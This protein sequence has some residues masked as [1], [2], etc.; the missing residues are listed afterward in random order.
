M[1]G[2]LWLWQIY[3][4]NTF[5]DRYVDRWRGMFCFI[6]ID[7]FS[8]AYRNRYL[9]DVNEK[10]GFDRVLRCFHSCFI[11][12]FCT[13]EVY[14]NHFYEIKSKWPILKFMI[15]NLKMLHTILATSAKSNSCPQTCMNT[16]ALTLVQWWRHSIMLSLQHM[17]IGSKQTN[18][19]MDRMITQAIQ[20]LTRVLPMIKI[21]H[22]SCKFDQY[23]SLVEFI[24]FV[25]D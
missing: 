10:I 6:F 14:Q 25:T 9:I 24:S 16:V 19:S 1:R 21:W 12:Y 15:L 3:M 18:Q 23:L 13:R 5:I 2:I 11:T 22:L 8:F 17:E 4:F 20:Q 7:Y